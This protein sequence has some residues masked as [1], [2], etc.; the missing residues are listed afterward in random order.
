MVL[1]FVVFEGI[2]GSGKTTQWE[3]IDDGWEKIKFPTYKYVPEI[4]DFLSGKLKLEEKTAF[5][6]FLADIYE[7]VSRLSN[8]AV[9]DRYVFSTI[10]YSH[11][12]PVEDAA[13]VI[14]RVGMPKPDLVI[15]LDIEPK[16]ALERRQK[17]SSSLSI[18]ER[19]DA[20]EETYRRYDELR[21]M[22]VLGEDWLVIDAQQPIEEI[23]SKISGVLAS[24]QRGV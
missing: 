1:P 8:K 21:R 10:A 7:G 17:A 24:L 4:R 12:I 16:L 20:L 22:R 9:F 2:D 18:R 19:L 15:Y 23:S 14:K 6:L 5:L 3:R 11:N 13:E